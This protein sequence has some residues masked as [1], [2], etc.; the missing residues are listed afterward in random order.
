M[1]HCSF[2]ASLL[3]LH[4]AFNPHIRS[5]AEQPV[6]LLTCRR[7]LKSDLSYYNTQKAIG[8]IFNYARAAY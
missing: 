7:Q 6:V 8:K 1:T 5:V 3:V 2:S 4:W